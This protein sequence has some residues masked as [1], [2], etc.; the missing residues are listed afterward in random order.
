MIGDTDR[1][2]LKTETETDIKELAHSIG[3][4]GDQQS[5]LGRA[6]SQ[7]SIKNDT[8]SVNVQIMLE[9]KSLEL[10]SEVWA[11]GLELRAVCI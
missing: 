9:F 1:Q 10:R 8:S 6:G 3:E 5:G 7:G 11:K 4:A 2:V